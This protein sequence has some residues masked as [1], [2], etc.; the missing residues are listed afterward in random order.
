M[1]KYWFYAI[2][3]F[4]ISTLLFLILAEKGNRNEQYFFAILSGII[5]IGLGILDPLRR[6]FKKQDEEY[7]KEDTEKK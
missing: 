1:R 7:K 5:S 4:L 3:G 2:V 6:Y